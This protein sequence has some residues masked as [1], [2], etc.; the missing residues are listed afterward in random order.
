VVHHLIELGMRSMHLVLVASCHVS[1]AYFISNAGK[2]E[3]V[4]T[5][6]VSLAIISADDSHSQR[7]MKERKK[8]GRTYNH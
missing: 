8:E 6:D 3:G 4:R 7:R 1:S 2:V 5:H